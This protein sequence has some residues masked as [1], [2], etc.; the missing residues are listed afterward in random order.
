[1]SELKEADYIALL[2]KVEKD[3]LDALDKY[4]QILAT[5][6]GGAGAAAATPAILLATGVTKV[7]ILG[8]IGSWVGLSVTAAT[9]VGWIVGMGAAGAAAGYG[10][11]KLCSSGGRNSEKRDRLKEDLKKKLQNA[12]QEVASAKDKDKGKILGD[13]LHT[14]YKQGKLSQADGLALLA[15]VKAKQITPEYAI[16]TLNSVIAA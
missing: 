10:L 13:L 12:R 11:Y 2:E 7:G 5:I 15:S 1:M 16:D 8:T 3:G 6:L 14:A 9:P 4:G